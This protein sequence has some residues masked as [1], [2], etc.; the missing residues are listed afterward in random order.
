MKR[1]LVGGQEE[2]NDQVHQAEDRFGGLKKASFSILLGQVT[3][4][5]FLQCGHG[6]QNNDNYFLVQRHQTATRRSN[7]WPS[8][9]RDSCS[10]HYD[11]VFQIT[12]VMPVKRF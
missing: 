1:R 6:T 4:V 11:Y 9:L 2:V 10:V 8:D 5:A 7:F 3:Q 12:Y